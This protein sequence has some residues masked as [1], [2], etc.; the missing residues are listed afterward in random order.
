M[1]DCS[2]RIAAYDKHTFITQAKLE[3]TRAVARGGDLATQ[4]AQLEEK[5]K[6]ANRFWLKERF[7]IPANGIEV[8]EIVFHCQTACQPK[9]LNVYHGKQEF[10]FTLSG[11]AR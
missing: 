8:G 9:Q 2:R 11:V 3:S 4:R 1:S 7:T 6:W 5:S 10:P